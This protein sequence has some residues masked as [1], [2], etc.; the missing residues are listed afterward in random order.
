[1]KARVGTS[2]STHRCT[3][4]RPSGAGHRHLRRPARRRAAFAWAGLCG[5][6]LLTRARCLTLSLPLSL[7]LS[8]SLCL[9]LSLSLSLSAYACVCV[10]VLCAR[11]RVW[12]RTAR[13]QQQ[14][15]PPLKKRPSAAA[16]VAAD[17][18]AAPWPG[19]GLRRPP[20]GPAP[21]KHPTPSPSSS[22][23]RMPVNTHD[24]LLAITPPPLRARGVEATQR[25]HRVGDGGGSGGGGWR[26][27][28]AQSSP[29]RRARPASPS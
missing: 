13:Q 15:H 12:L 5:R 4:M 29:S 11:A 7:S 9:S 25:R 27:G 22:S 10:C 28:F 16:R 3:S 2:A 8:L 23:G 26:Q 1:V 18:A 19:Q 14:L 20:R 6:Q 24:E 17:G 21:S